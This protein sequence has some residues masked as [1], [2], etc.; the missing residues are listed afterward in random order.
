M[1]LKLLSLTCILL[2]AAST[3]AQISG[4]VLGQHQ[5]GSGSNPYVTG[6]ASGCIYCHAPHS[7]IGSGTALWNQK[8]S[9]ATYVPY[10]SS[11]YHQK[12]N[13]IPPLGADSSLCLSCHDGTIAPGSSIAYGNMLMYGSMNKTDL[14][15][16]ADINGQHSL[17]PD[18]PFSLVLPIVD[19][20]D[21]IASLVLQGRTGDVS[22]AVSLVK[23]N[24]ECTTCHN[25][26]VQNKDKVS[27]N[28][29]VRD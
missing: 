21:L 26:H 11:T 19:S 20:P 18:H 2:M 9:R 6:V 14:I 16:A 24:V 3:Q 17:Q 12:G 10:T 29:L 13:Q 25:P 5:M 1:K 4:D 8:L 15:G 22:G 27:Q 23:G 7:G 28:F